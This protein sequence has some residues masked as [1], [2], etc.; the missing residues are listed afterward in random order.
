MFDL[1]AR[2]L[3]ETR[4]YVDGAWTDADSGA[5]FAV[6]NPANGEEIARLADLGRAETTRAIDAAY[7]AQPV[8]AAKT[9]KE[10]AV[11]MRR[12]FDLIVENADDLARLLT[13]EQGKPLAEARP[14]TSWCCWPARP[15]RSPSSATPT[16]RVGWLQARRPSSP[17]PER[18]S[19]ELSRPLQ[20]PWARERLHRSRLRGP[21]LR[22]PDRST[23]Q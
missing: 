13:A 16:R 14:P 4:S 8:W 15:S 3:L 19:Q 21:A 9:A 10:R 12:W 5:T 18:T 22:E 1:S 23:Q 20:T 17:S 11:I 6:T 2:N 7:A